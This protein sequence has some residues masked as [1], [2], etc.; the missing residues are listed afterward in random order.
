MEPNFLDE[1][2]DVFMSDSEIRLEER[3]KGEVWRNFKFSIR[4][5][6]YNV[7]N[8]EESAWTKAKVETPW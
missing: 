2:C 3:I 4:K 6:W 7:I 5:Q 1:E 8:Y